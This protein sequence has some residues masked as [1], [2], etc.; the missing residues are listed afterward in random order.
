MYNVSNRNMNIITEK[1]ELS[2]LIEIFKKIYPSEWYWGKYKDEDG[3]EYNSLRQSKMSELDTF[4]KFHIPRTYSEA[5]KENENVSKKR[6][7]LEEKFGEAFEEYG[8]DASS[9]SWAL[10]A[11]K[12]W[13]SNLSAV[14]VNVDGAISF[15]ESN[16]KG[17][18]R[19]QQKMYWRVHD[20][21]MAMDEMYKGAYFVTLTAGQELR[22]KG[23]FEAWKLFSKQIG[24]LTKKMRATFECEV[25]TVLEA[26][27]SGFPHAHMVVYLPEFIGDEKEHYSRRQKRKYVIRGTMRRFLDRNWKCGFAD[28]QKNVRKG[29]ANYL[30]KYIAKSADGSLKDLLKK[31]E[32]TKAEKK[33]LL[34]I[35]L[36]IMTGVRGFRFSQGKLEYFST[37]NKFLRV[38]GDAPESVKKEMLGKKISEQVQ[39]LKKAR[40]DGEP[41]TETERFLLEQLDFI[42][43]GEFEKL[44]ENAKRS[45]LIKL[46]TKLLFACEKRV[47]VTN[48]AQLDKKTEGDIFSET[49]LSA[50]QKEELWK[51]CAP[52]K[53]EGCIITHLLNKL[54]TG[55]DEWFDNGMKVTDEREIQYMNNEVPKCMKDF[56][57]FHTQGA[58][59]RTW[60]FNPAMREIEKN[61]HWLGLKYSD[62]EN[63]VW[64]ML[65]NYHGRDHI[66]DF[67]YV[68]IDNLSPFVKLD[69]KKREEYT[70]SL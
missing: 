66:F 70:K 49:A 56:F 52:L 33:M 44:D 65:R 50:P 36:P 21:C 62:Y 54:R 14:A 69:R 63:T 29:T 2:I 27:E 38:R 37:L 51:S 31:K 34:T 42:N 26:H 17:T 7:S 46:S 20:F 6:R 39:I 28:L 25:C 23:L 40:E 12:I 4:C 30:S 43:S 11:L 60:V 19:Y 64:R 55:E 3:N 13:R 35:L 15:F 53:C 57:F 9:F 59:P 41:K 24:R 16:A 48:Y 61:S 5:P 47:R 22:S 67:T 32:L 68:E 8:K 18:K 10:K 58:D 1:R 45:Y